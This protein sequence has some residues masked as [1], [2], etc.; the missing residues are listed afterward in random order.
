M[1]RKPRAG[2][3]FAKSNAIETETYTTDAQ[4]CG[5]RWNLVRCKRFIVNP[6]NFRMT[7]TH[8]AILIFLKSQEVFI[9][10]YT[11]VRVLT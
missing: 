6:L 2:R 8:M 3:T 7:S 1:R 5:N 9:N 10:P 4:L 11:E